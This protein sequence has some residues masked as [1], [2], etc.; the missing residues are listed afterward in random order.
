MHVTS[1]LP[2]VPVCLLVLLIRILVARGSFLI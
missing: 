2:K 1:K